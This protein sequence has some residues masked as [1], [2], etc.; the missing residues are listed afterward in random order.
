MSINEEIL[1]RADVD[2]LEAI[3]AV[4]NSDRDA[5]IST[6][7]QNA[8]AIFTWDYTKGAR[9]A[10]DKLYE[11]AKVSMWNG[12]TDLPW[13]TEVDQESI[14]IANAEQNSGVNG[15]GALGLADFDVTGT[16]FEKWTPDQW[17]RLGIE[18][19]NWTLSQ[20]MHGEQGALICT[21][22]IVETVPWID[23]KYYASTQVMDEARHVE[24]FARY[25]DTKLSGH[26]PVNAHLKMLLDDI[27]TD[28]R[29]DMTYLG[30]QVMVEGLALASFGFMHQMS[31]EPL[32][33]QLLRYVMS[34]EARHV[35]FGVLSL[36]EYY[37]NLSDAEI[38]ERQQFAFEAAVRMRDRFLQQEVWERMDV[39]VKDAIEAVMRTPTRQL[40][41]IM[42]FS[43]IVP[44]CKKLGLLDRNDAWLRRRFEEIGV[45]QFED[46]EDTGSEYESFA[47]TDA[48]Q[49]SA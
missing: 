2:D 26:Y 13:D 28:S 41:Q 3:L 9:P 21:A 25:L 22:K 36:Q 12:E 6:V 39:P 7:Q 34:D 35:A 43:K 40:F 29:W 23:A 17:M 5:V 4:S 37:A 32:L 45:I 30:M 44:N 27:I 31:T 16:P 19:Q 1:G 24:V 11:K 47:L 15:A 8:E 42:L 18:S 20:F 10:L 38:F 48:D 49:R 14:V 46:W 33:K